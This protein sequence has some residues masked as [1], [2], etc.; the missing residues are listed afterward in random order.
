M[1]AENNPT[2][3]N[4]SALFTIRLYGFGPNKK[5]ERSPVS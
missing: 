4:V 3:K 5:V 1:K 2:P